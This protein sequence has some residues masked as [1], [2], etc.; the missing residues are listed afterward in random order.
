MGTD[1]IVRVLPV[2]LRAAERGEIQI[3]GVRFVTLFCMGAIGA[4][5]R[6]IEVRRAWRQDKE[7]NTALLAGLFD[8][9]GEFTAAIDL[10]RLNREMH[11]VEQRLKEARGGHT[12]RAAVGLHDVPAR[13]DI[14]GGELLEDEAGQGA[15][16]QRLDRHQIPRVASRDRRGACGSHTGGRGDAG[17]PRW[18][19]AVAR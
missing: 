7:P 3:A 16:I 2:A 18:R 12:R 6:A 8:G 14:A 10:K 11:P 15:D 1:M 13:D 17:A 5:D 19:A 4:F 9:G